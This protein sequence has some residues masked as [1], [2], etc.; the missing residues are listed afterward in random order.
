MKYRVECSDIP[1]FVEEAGLLSCCCCCR[2]QEAT[3]DL[4]KPI[5]E[6][7]VND[8]KGLLHWSGKAAV[9][10]TQQAKPIEQF[11]V[12]DVKRLL[13]W[14]GED[15]VVVAHQSFLALA[16]IVSN[17]FNVSAVTLH[18]ALQRAGV[19]QFVYVAAGMKVPTPDFYSAG[20]LGS[21]VTKHRVPPPWLP[22]IWVT[23][24]QRMG[25]LF[26]SALFGVAESVA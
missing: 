7:S 16:P 8:V 4:T 21:I 25:S 14:S 19:F 22:L 15:R 24:S 17:T 11:T 1:S 5:E 18:N 2:T 26:P 20:G 9:T 10:K 6:F 13:D 23:T 12:D 3:V